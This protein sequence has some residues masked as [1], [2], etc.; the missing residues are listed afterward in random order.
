MIDALTSQ[1]LKH[2]RERWWDEQFTEF[3][4]ETLKPRPG[5]RILDVGCGEGLAEVSIGRLHI[6]QIR[7]TGVDLYPSK[8]A[9]ARRV[10]RSHNQ[11]VDFIAG[12]ACRLPLASASFD[13]IFCVAVLQH[14]ADV[15]TAVAEIARV[16]RTNGRIVA[17]EP[18]NSARYLYSSVPS[19]ERTFAASSAFFAAVSA[20]AGETDGTI[21]PKLPSLFAAHGVD[22]TDVRL[23]PVS[24]SQLGA[25]ATSRR[26]VVAARRRDARAWQRDERRGAAGGRRICRRAH[27][28]RRRGDRGRAGVRRDPEHDALRHH[29][30]AAWLSPAAT[31]TKGGTTTRR[32]TTGRT[33]ARLAAAMCPFGGTWRATPVATSSNWAVAPVASRSRSGAPA[34]RS[35]ASIAQNRC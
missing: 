4:A 32:S 22:V 19:G 13:S 27:G 20:E 30:S 8:V 26:L 3:L 7:L 15:P 9:E 23:F 12:D 2:L 1:T 6:S 11:R 17:V 29:R 34:S 10:T 21:G 18:D 24:H 16:A 14:V 35:L 5:N 31:G 25:R 33:R 28:I